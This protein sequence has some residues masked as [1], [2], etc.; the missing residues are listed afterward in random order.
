MAFSII[1]AN[2]SSALAQTL[3]SLA[4]R[5]CR[6]HCGARSITRNMV[7][8]VGSSMQRLYEGPDAASLKNRLQIGI[9]AIKFELRFGQPHA[10][11]FH[12]TIAFL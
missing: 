3:K 12:G 6:S 7:I 9:G 11:I 4:S 10:M 2:V 1:P 5:S 8:L